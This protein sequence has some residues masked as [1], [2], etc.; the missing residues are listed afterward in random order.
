MD[1]LHEIRLRIL[2]VVIPQATRVG[3]G[4]PDN[5]VTVCTHLEK[6]VLD[7]AQIGEKLSDSPTK[8]PP[9]R[10]SNKGTTNHE[11]NGNLGPATGG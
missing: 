9:G 5:I 2:E 3:L 11:M 7:F 1:D 6:Y 4:E 10:P 8:R